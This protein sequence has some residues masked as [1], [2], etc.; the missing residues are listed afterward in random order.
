MMWKIENDDLRISGDAF[1][2]MI[3][4]TEILFDCRFYFHFPESDY[5]NLTVCNLFYTG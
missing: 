1:H 4:R 2:I 3:S 5:R